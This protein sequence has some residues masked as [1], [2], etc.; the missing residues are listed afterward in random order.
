MSY[1]GGDNPYKR[2]SK[3]GKGL[4]FLKGTQGTI[5]PLE[6]E[7]T[8]NSRTYTISVALVDVGNTGDYCISVFFETCTHNGIFGAH[9]D[10]YNHRMDYRFRVINTHAT[11]G[12]LNT[13][14]I[15][16]KQGGSYQGDIPKNGVGLEGGRINFND[17]SYLKA[18][19]ELPGGLIG[20]YTSA[21]TFT[22][23][24]HYSF[25]IL[26][27]PF[28]I[29]DFYIIIDNSSSSGTF[30]NLKEVAGNTNIAEGH[31]NFSWDKGGG[32]KAPRICQIYTTDGSTP[33]SIADSGNIRLTE[34][35]YRVE[36]KY[37]GYLA[38][39][40]YSS[41]TA[42]YYI[43]VLPYA[44]P[45][46]NKDALAGNRFNGVKTKWFDV[47]DNERI[48][49]FYDENKAMGYAMA[50]EEKN[51]Q[52]ETAF[53]LQYCNKYTL[54]Q[55]IYNKYAGTHA[56]K[57]AQIRNNISDNQELTAV[58]SLYAQKN[59]KRVYFDPSDL[60]ER[61]FD[62]DTMFDNGKLWLDDDFQFVQ[63]GTW[64]SYSVAYRNNATNATGTI[65]YYTS[66]KNLN[67]PDGVYTITEKD[68][69]NQTTV[70][71]AYRDKTAPSVK[72]GANGATAET[73]GNGQ[74]YTSDYWTIA[75]FAD[76]Y[77][78]WAVIKINDKYYVHQDWLSATYYKSG[79][80]AVSAYDRNG[81]ILTFT[82]IVKDR[83]ITPRLA[84]NNT[85]NA[86]TPANNGIYEVYNFSFSLI[87]GT[88][89]DTFYIIKINGQIK[90]YAES[91]VFTTGFGLYN[92]QIT[93]KY[94][95]N[96][97][98]FTVEIKERRLE[99]FIIWDDDE[100]VSAESLAVYS[101]NR[102]KLNYEKAYID[103]TCNLS[104]NF[105]LYISTQGVY[106]ITATDIYNGNAFSFSVTVEDKDISLGIWADDGN[107][108]V[109]SGGESNIAKQFRLIK[110]GSDRL[111]YMD[112]FLNGQP[113]D[114]AAQL[115]TAAGVYRIY[116]ENKFNG[117][118]Y[119]SVLVI[120][121]RPVYADILVNNDAVYI[122]NDGVQGVYNFIIGY[123]P[124][125]IDLYANGRAIRQSG[126]KFTAPGLYDLI[127]LDRYNGN[128]AVYRL[129]VIG[130][131]D[132]Q[133]ADID[134]ER[135]LYPAAT[136]D[137]NT[138]LNIHESGVY[139][140]YRF[141]LGAP[142]EY[143]S[144]YVN[145]EPF[146]IYGYIFAA[147]EYAV[148]L[149]DIYNDK[150]FAFTLVV[151]PMIDTVGL[152]IDDDTAIGITDGLTIDVKRFKTGLADLLQT[153]YLEVS[154]NGR[155]YAPNNVYVT[156][157]GTYAFRL[158]NIY[159]DADIAFTVMVKARSL[160]LPILYNNDI[161]S[162]LVRDMAALRFRLADLTA[163]REFADITP[164]I[165]ADYENYITAYGVY[166]FVLR[167][168]YNG[169]ALTID[170]TVSPI[171]GLLSL[172]D[173]KCVLT[174]GVAFVYDDTLYTLSLRVDGRAAEIV[175]GDTVGLTAL[176]EE[177]HY[178]LVFTN[179]FDSADI[180]EV[181]LIIKK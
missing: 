14:K 79:T 145:G 28:Y 94:N 30:D 173:N 96:A 9:V 32:S 150:S 67:L 112:V 42:V 71:T 45:S 72:I 48:M 178:Y 146:T 167:D 114:N 110:I 69:Y 91:S 92:Y 89:I 5:V 141:K 68:I 59:V 37:N 170:I 22:A 53:M 56:S 164:G 40:N 163:L 12:S 106:Q 27:G 81:N 49:S 111:Y 147:G 57:I 181:Y 36:V 148:V 127:I 154:L 54:I 41:T 87:N 7:I 29:E 44:P 137:L 18:T 124:D 175:G 169:A 23:R 165:A 176:N 17:I 98:G 142:E 99:A 103:V 50:A 135:G 25:T 13:I 168:R 31:S 10:V 151:K 66:I 160:S 105:D 157:F 20:E 64:E 55:T 172:K 129:W 159:S 19:V 78:D 180:Y 119:E 24:G 3:V 83:A 152:T 63:I 125:Y 128:Q 82:L 97:W 2:D 171:S 75:E 60:T 139:Y 51:V 34:G 39:G 140:V 143:Q 77:D 126:A 153:E 115:I 38:A 6:P 52:N 155:K 88:F 73:A 61:E 118:C 108:Y 35:N 1:I 166:R 21:V 138:S 102:F 43:N 74:T 16:N 46:Q 70:F 122:P 95:G 161:E 100:V 107:S 123:I 15:E 104:A 33:I 134:E 62:P 149:T 86:Y 133:Y 130:A 120:E 144:L 26:R 76:N 93:D 101:V 174:H 65:P 136:A 117:K 131:N 179:L 84:V 156:A 8:A 85:E 90:T 109:L 11:D 116:A 162:G 113:Y 58:M 158:H 4:V 177:T 47:Y 121:D 132:D 80:Y